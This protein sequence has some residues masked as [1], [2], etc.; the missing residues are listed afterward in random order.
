MLACGHVVASAGVL[1]AQVV[2]SFVQNYEEPPTLLRQLLRRR[3]R[4]A[5]DR[6][7]GL[8]LFEEALG[9]LDFPA[10]RRLLLMN[11]VAAL[12]RQHYL[13]HLQA[14]PPALG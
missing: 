14:C 3:R 1:C 13:A 6:S 9:Y 5:R 10:V 7:T 12:Q 4:R 8:G 11:L 2:L